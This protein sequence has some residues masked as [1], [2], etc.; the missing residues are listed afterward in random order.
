MLVANR[1]MVVFYCLVRGSAKI[2][3]KRFSGSGKRRLKEMHAE[4]TV[5][6]CATLADSERTKILMRLGDGLRWL[7]GR[8]IQMPNIVCGCF[9]SKSI[10]F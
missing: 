1:A 6:V 5:S 4:N 7:P 2:R 9:F 10:R 8:I 3:S